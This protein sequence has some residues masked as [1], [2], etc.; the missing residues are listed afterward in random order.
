M[1][2]R[3][4]A[5]ATV[6]GLGVVTTGLVYKHHQAFFPLPGDSTALAASAVTLAPHQYEVNGTVHELR[7]E[8]RR[9]VGGSTIT[10]EMRDVPA[11]EVAAE[12]SRLANREVT[13][14]FGADTQII[15][16]SLR[17][18]PFWHALMALC[19]TGN[20]GFTIY[21]QP[22][23][24]IRVENDPFDGKVT[25][26]TVEGPLMLAWIGGRKNK[27]KLLVEPTSSAFFLDPVINPDFSVMFDGGQQREMQAAKEAQDGMGGRAWELGPDL[28]GDVTS[29]SVALPLA[30]LLRSH[31]IQAPWLGGDYES[32][33][34]LLGVQSVSSK[35]EELPDPADP[36]QTL[37][38]RVHTATFRLRHP[39]AALAERL[40]GAPTPEQSE[41]LAL[42]PE[43]AVLHAHGVWAL[44][45]DGTRLE[46][47]VES[48]TG[49]S[50]PWHGYA[51]EAV[52]TTSDASFEPTKFGV[53][54]AEG[55]DTAEVPFQLSEL[56]PGSVTG[57]NSP[58][59]RKRRRAD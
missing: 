40:Q 32:E 13:L 51:Y 9:W 50:S 49:I 20:W 12:L 59:A 4:L 19:Q 6:L 28:P 29:L 21:G 53:H 43:G 56:P 33:V 47:R 39:A 35:V 46:G 42:L 2:L 10:L 8:V 5:I 41:Q 26:F 1:V 25:A 17:N 34:V 7:A 58:E 45:A 14:G 55:Y 27:L 23:H 37:R 16:L 44:A 36:F 48:A 57:W 24:P 11:A 30:G 3:A 31:A 15:S 38:R 54:V 18:A 52:F 22:G